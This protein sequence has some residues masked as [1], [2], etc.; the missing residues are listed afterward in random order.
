MNRLNK[1]TKWASLALL[2]VGGTPLVAFAQSTPADQSLFNRLVSGESPEILAIAILITLL[3]ILTIPLLVMVTQINRI[4]LK[5]GH[6]AEAKKVAAMPEELR[7]EMG[8]WGWFWDKFNAAVPKAKEA[9]IML[10][11]DYDGIKEL[12]NN[13]PPWWKWGFVVTVFYAVFYLYVYHWSSDEDAPPS[14]VEYRQDMEAGEKARQAYLTKMESNIDETNVTVDLANAALASGKD[15][16]MNNCATCHAADGGGKA[17]PNLTDQYWLHGGGIQDIFKTIKYGVIKK[18]MIPWEKK[19]TPK[20]MQEVASYVYTLEGT[21]PAEP[22]DPQGEKYIRE[23]GD[24]G[25]EKAQTDNNADKSLA[26]N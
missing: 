9:D 2:L 17:G 26:G 8:F 6:E 4:L 21:T 23:E 24:G 5:T 18:G 22:K 20:Q 13:L 19:L 10:D 3:I 1:S 11:H 14:I 12:D 16:F 15:I 7:P 25:E